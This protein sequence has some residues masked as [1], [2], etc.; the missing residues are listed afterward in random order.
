M[1]TH[2]YTVPRKVSYVLDA[3]HSTTFGLM[4]QLTLTTFILKYEA[5]RA[6]TQV[7]RVE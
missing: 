5:C 4:A 3:C 7:P 2:N 1:N 6:V